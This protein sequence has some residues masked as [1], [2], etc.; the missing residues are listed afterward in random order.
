MRE[1]SRWNRGP[2]RREPLARR[3]GLHVAVEQ[4]RH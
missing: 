2:G 3:S 1:E 4:R